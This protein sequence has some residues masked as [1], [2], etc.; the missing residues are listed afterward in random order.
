MCKFVAFWIAKSVFFVHQVF[1]IFNRPLCVRYCHK[2][3]SNN[4]SNN[5]VSNGDLTVVVIFCVTHLF[6]LM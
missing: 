5:S 4:S 3:C 2:A 6:F 1:L